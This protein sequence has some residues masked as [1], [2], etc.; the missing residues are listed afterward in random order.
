MWPRTARAPSRSRTCSTAPTATRF[1][2]DKTSLDPWGKTIFRGKQA[3]TLHP[4]PQTPPSLPAT[5]PSLAPTVTL[6]L[7]APSAVCPPPRA[8]LLPS[9]LRSFLGRPPCSA[10]EGKRRALF[11]V[12]Q[13][14]RMLLQ[15]ACGR[16]ADA[17]LLGVFIN[18]AVPPRAGA[19]PAIPASLRHGGARTIRRFV[20]APPARALAPPGL[21]PLPPPPTSPQVLLVWSLV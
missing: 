19:G 9:P 7:L 4:Q 21:S 8:L 16:H 13:V 10:H 5:A 1:P 18:L 17:E 20:A 14:A 15:Q 12:R 6:V 2:S 11:R 3:S